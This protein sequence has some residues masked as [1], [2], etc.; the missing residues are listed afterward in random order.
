MSE[1]MKDLI[2]NNNSKEEKLLLQYVLSKAGLDTSFMIQ[3]IFLGYKYRKRVGKLYESDGYI[4]TNLIKFYYSLN[5]TDIEFDNMKKGFITRYVKNESEL[6]GVNDLDIH[7][8]DEILGM[9]DMYEYLHSEEMEQYFSMYS[10][11]DL[12]RKLMG[13]TAHP[14]CSGNFRTFPAYLPGTGIELAEWTMIQRELYALSPTI[15]KLHDYAKV[16]KATG[17]V[18]ELLEFLDQCIRLKVE[19]I[20]I[21]PCSDGNGRTV[22]AFIN[23]LLEDAGLPPIY[24]KANER[25]EYHTAMNKALIDGD[26]SSINAFYRYKI[27]DSIIELDINDRVKKINKELGINKSIEENSKQKTKDLK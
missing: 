7:G 13:H 27:C 14:E 26:Y 2:E 25:T 19:L 21:H 24:V 12:H 16:V 9:A 17:D 6:E 10:L 15:D 11:K 20:R 8:H 5:P 3:E 18:K 1:E 23:K 22:R 4:P